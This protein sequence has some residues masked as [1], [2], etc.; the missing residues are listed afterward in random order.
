MY[1]NSKNIKNKHFIKIPYIL[2]Y[3]LFDL[4]LKNNK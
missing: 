1:G 2:I 3:L 4:Y